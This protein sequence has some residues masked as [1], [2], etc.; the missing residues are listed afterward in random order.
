MPLDT[1][2]W[3]QDTDDVN[4]TVTI[5]HNTS[6]PIEDDRSVRFTVTTGGAIS[7]KGAGA[8][9]LDIA[10]HTKGFELGRIRTL[11]RVDQ[12][13]DQAGIFAMGSID[14]GIAGA[15]NSYVFGPV[16]VT[17]ELTLQKLDGGLF[18]VTPSLIDATGVTFSIGAVKA[19]ELEWKADVG[20]FGGT[21]LIC[22]AG[23][24][25]DFS[26]LA[27]IFQGVDETA[28]LTASL[29]EGLFAFRAGITSVG[30][31]T[32]DDTTVFKTT[33]VP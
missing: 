22:R 17:N 32:F 21:Q 7:D 8:V 6:T 10:S 15:G 19:I 13:V 18:D 4:S 9:Y 27:I 28:P 14:A 3:I 29:S 11:I 31:V 2:D 33:I 30:Q 26:D 20:I 5:L 25:T 23:D 12:Q 24:A 1:N 16:G